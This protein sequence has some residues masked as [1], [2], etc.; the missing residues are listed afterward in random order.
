MNGSST[1]HDPASADVPAST[2][3]TGAALDVLI[4][5]HHTLVREA[6]RLLIDREPDLNVVGQAS[7]PSEAEQLSV[8]PDVIVADIEQPTGPGGVLSALG[9]SFPGGRT[10]V[11]TA[12]SHPGAVQDALSAGAAGYLLKTASSDDLLSAIRTV[13]QGLS[14]LQPSLGVELARWHF[15]WGAAGLSPREERVLALLATGHTNEEIAE[16]LAVSLRTVETHRSRVMQ[17]TGV[18]TRAELFAFAYRAGL[19]RLW[20]Q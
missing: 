19:L 3:E 20:E 16:R 14:Y 11:L 6:L 18:R 12:M 8:S 10:L 1:R 5:D 15:A 17:K 2:Q 9:E 4:V 13:A 7:D